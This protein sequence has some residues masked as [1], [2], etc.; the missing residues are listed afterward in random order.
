MIDHDYDAHSDERS[1]ALF[2]SLSG[3]VRH[4]KATAVRLY[5]FYNVDRNQKGEPFRLCDECLKIQPVP[6]NCLLEKIADAPIGC[7]QSDNH[8]I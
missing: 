5:R 3:G 2:R 4:G 6:L 7:C 1:K 8:F